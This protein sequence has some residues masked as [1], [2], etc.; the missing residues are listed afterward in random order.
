MTRSHH[1]M[2]ALPGMKVPSESGRLKP[3]AI[4]HPGMDDQEIGVL[5]RKL[6]RTAT[7]EQFQDDA[8]WVTRL[9]GDTEMKARGLSDEKLFKGRKIQLSLYPDKDHGGWDYSKGYQWA[10][11]IDQ[12]ACIGCNACVVLVGVEAELYFSALEELL[13]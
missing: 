13:V 4:E 3:R 7:L 2:A 1:A 10:M 9:G 8:N 12:T 6:V 11:S 5:N